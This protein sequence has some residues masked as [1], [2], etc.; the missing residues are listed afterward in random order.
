MMTLSYAK[1]ALISDLPPIKEVVTDN[2]NAFL[3]KSEDVIDLSE[4]LNLILCD[5]QNLERV[6][7]NGRILM[8]KK[9]SWNEIGRLTKIAYQTL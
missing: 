1:A 8:Q 2:E 6:S 7:K 9:F 3:F 4:K 5:K